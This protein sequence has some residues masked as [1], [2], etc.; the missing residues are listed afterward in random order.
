MSNIE[1]LAASRRSRVQRA[2]R[3]LLSRNKKAFL[4]T[5]CTASKAL[6]AARSAQ[7][8]TACSWCW[9]RFP[10]LDWPGERNRGLVSLWDSLVSPRLPHRLPQ[11]QS[12]E[13]GESGIRDQGLRC[14]EH[15]LPGRGLQCAD[16]DPPCSFLPTE[17]P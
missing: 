17:P 2:K 6:A 12:L 8:R 10:W 9:R 13:G 4:G 1:G 14:K 16:G 5:E 11:L 15:H 7:P 3:R